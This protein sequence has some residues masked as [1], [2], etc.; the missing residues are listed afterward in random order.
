[1]LDEVE[2]RR[3]LVEPA[4]EDALPTS[5]RVA[6]VE[7][8][9][10]AGQLLHLPGRAGLAGA[11]PHHRIPDPHRLSRLQR[12]V[13]G[14]AVALVEEAEHRHALRHRRRPGR[15]RGHGL[16]YVD[17]PGL[18]GRLAVARLLVFAAATAAGEG[19]EG[20]KGGA[21]RE[22]HARSGVQAS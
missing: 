20:E 15:D 5:L 8:D 17:R 9:E 2:R 14:D 12:E 13:A 21:G 4:R 10:G 1:V 22:P 18:A 11:Q 19:G 6:D 3:F 16:R 7:L